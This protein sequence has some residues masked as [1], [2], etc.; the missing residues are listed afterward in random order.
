MKEE[1]EKLKER[2]KMRGGEDIEEEAI[3]VERKPVRIKSL[4]T[5]TSEKK[6]TTPSRV[7]WEEKSYLQH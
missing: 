6:T 7:T 5:S 1:E 3:V 4:L 2:M